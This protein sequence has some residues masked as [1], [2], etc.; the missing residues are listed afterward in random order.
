VTRP[1]RRRLVIAL[2]IGLLCSSS[3]RADYKRAY[4]EG[5]QLA[6]QGRDWE[7]VATKMAEAL[8]ENDR[9][10]EQVVLTS[11]NTQPYL[12]YFYL[13][14]ARFHLGDCRGARENW[15]KT[16]VQKKVVLHGRE[17]EWFNQFSP[18]CE[19]TVSVEDAFKQT[20]SRL[21][22]LDELARDADLG[23]VWTQEPAFAPGVAKLRQQFDQARAS[24]Q[25][26]RA[27]KVEQ[28]QAFLTSVKADATQLSD[29]TETLLKTARGRREE[30]VAQ[31]LAT[32]NE[33]RLAED[34]KA[35]SNTTTG[36]NGGNTA[37]GGGTSAETKPSDAK[38]VETK[39]GD[40]KTVDAKT[41]E[42]KNAEAK[43]A[44]ADARGVGTKGLGTK[45]AGTT[46]AATT[47]A[48]S[49]AP[50]DALRAVAQHYVKGRYREAH[51]RLQSQAVPAEWRAHAALLRAASAFSLYYAEGQK[52][53]KL[54]DEASRAVQLCAQAK[55]DLRPSPRLYTPPFVEFF[56]RHARP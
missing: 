41:A 16:S 24:L 21:Q 45:A 28:Q 4:Y 14:L 25:E 42:L 19:L 33:K 10:G 13:G 47:T 39:T 51:D 7:T 52:D 5:Y 18:I 32:A 27:A 44:V 26:A 53:R 43:N 29:Q 46:A 40:S 48:A 20:Q 50:P 54:L 35:A 36:G 31:R 22:S 8:K 34:R 12:P 3:L 23:K 1:L 17:R 30:L 6:R 15:I 2:V 9:E 56:D 38:A 55:R 11:A 37:S 49:L